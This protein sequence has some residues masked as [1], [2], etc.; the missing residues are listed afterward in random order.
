MSL[1]AIRKVAETEQNTQLRKAEAVTGAKRLIA[2]AECR[3]NEAANELRTEA[4]A[5]AGQR[6]QEAERRA[7]DHA[8][9][10]MQE[11]QQSCHALRQAAAARLDSAAQLIVERVV[12][13]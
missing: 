6:M 4:E 13:I 2:E 11:T 9:A 5:T 3:A 1:E 8:A 7:A 12:N 10:V